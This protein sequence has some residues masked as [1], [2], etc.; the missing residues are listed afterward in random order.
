MPHKITESA[1]SEARDIE[2]SPE[3][4]H[5]LAQIQAFAYLIAGNPAASVETLRY[6]AKSRDIAISAAVAE[7]PNAPFDVLQSLLNEHTE[8]VLNN[9]ALPFLLVENP[10]LPAKLSEQDLLHILRYE[11]I[12]RVFLTHALYLP[13][14]EARR[15]AMMHVIVAGEADAAW[16]SELIR[17]FGEIALLTPDD[18]PL[19]ALPE[20][21]PLEFLEVLMEHP[22]NYA[23]LAL[24]PDLTTAMFDTL[25]KERNEMILERVAQN[26]AVP[27]RILEWLAAISSP[28]IQK[29]VARQHGLPS[30][31]LVAL[32]RDTHPDVRAVVASNESLPQDALLQLAHDSVDT[33][34]SI[35]AQ[36]PGIP[37][38]TCNLLAKDTIAAVRAAAAANAQIS[39]PMLEL[40]ARDREVSV[41][42]G[43]ACNPRIP[44][45]LIEQLAR[46]DNIDIQCALAQNPSITAEL[47]RRFM[48]SKQSRLRESLAANPSLPPDMLAKISQQT[49]D[50]AL[51]RGLARNPHA[52]PEILNWLAGSKSYTIRRAV[53]AHASLP[54]KAQGRLVQSH[55]IETLYALANNPAT[56]LSILAHIGE[57]V[58]PELLIKVVR[59]PAMNSATRRSIYHSYCAAWIKQHGANE[60]LRLFWLI[61]DTIQ[62]PVH[63]KGFDSIDWLDRLEI[64]QNPHSPKWMLV[65][66]S[67]DGN[68]F[69]RAAAR[70]SLMGK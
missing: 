55:D 69:I 54:L 16:R 24:C 34:R 31:A 66:L 40:L 64:A 9:P 59:H 10:A 47:A 49:D 44:K 1:R 35:V 6:L 56:S 21:F 48:M 37:E 20:F 22:R 38:A 65:R 45:S 4:L 39:L 43:V 7:N 42:A 36:H 13:G 68:R 26:P 25:V 41:R 28:A 61:A 53:A 32:A 17:Q 50:N 70:T 33:I 29:A 19:F 58:D 30:S 57:H 5:E 51:M 3:R 2:T 8:R 60:N 46:E 14:G 11:R 52:P 18:L 67:Q 23:Y 27:A 12:P 63:P 15:Q 62:E